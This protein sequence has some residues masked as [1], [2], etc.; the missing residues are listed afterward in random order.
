MMFA[1]IFGIKANKQQTKQRKHIFG[2]DGIYDSFQ[3]RG[4]QWK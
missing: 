2:Y 3:T 4:I 1:K